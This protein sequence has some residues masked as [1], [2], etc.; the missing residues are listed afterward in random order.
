MTL[1]FTKGN[2]LIP[3]IIQDDQSLN[4]LM[5][6]YMNEAALAK[7]LGEKKVTFYSRTKK[8]LWTKGETSGHFLWVSSIHTDC[9]QDALL[10]FVNAV[11]PT[12][13]LGTTSCFKDIPTKG[14][15]YQLEAIV[16][17]R[18]QN[19]QENSY[20]KKLVESGI[21]K[22]AQKVGEEAI[23]LVI[24]AKD[25]A[26]DLF[27]NEAADLLYHLLILI[28]MKGFSMQDIEYILESRHQKI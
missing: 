24:E 2:G 3:V 20:T 12:C 18:I 10:I 11:G 22:V 5:L 16:K 4:V 17:N 6:G 25:N 15:L 8:R 23:E 26:P 28:Q 9:D 13:H 27:K 19:G 1:D 14:F 7:T 21:N